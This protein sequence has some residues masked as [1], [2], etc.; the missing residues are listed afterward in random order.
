MRQHLFFLGFI[1]L[2]VWGGNQVGAAVSE[3]AKGRVPPPS[4]SQGVGVQPSPAAPPEIISVIPQP[5]TKTAPWPTPTPR[6]AISEYD[7]WVMGLI[8]KCETAGESF[9]GILAVAYV[10]VE[11]VKAE[12]RFEPWRY[13]WCWARAGGY[14]PIELTDEV[15]FALRMAF[16]GAVENPLPG[17][18]THYYSACLIDA[19]YWG[20]VERFV[21]QI[22]CH[23]F[24]NLW[25]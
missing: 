21:G 1:I 16:S 24:Y 18:A 11:Q 20:K 23:R 9:E 13:K 10:M 14:P 2:A 3:A 4:A 19:P 7:Y 8:L 17:P 15:N 12:G 25:D 6:V 5:N 22:G